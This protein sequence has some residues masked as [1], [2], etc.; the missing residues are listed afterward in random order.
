[1]LVEVEPKKKK[2]LLLVFWVVDVQKENDCNFDLD[3]VPKCRRSCLLK[4]KKLSNYKWFK[5]D[6]RHNFI[7]TKINKLWIFVP[8]MFNMTSNLTQNWPE[9]DQKGVLKLIKK[10]SKI[11]SNWPKINSNWPTL[12]QLHQKGIRNETVLV[13]FWTRNGKIETKVTW[14]GFV[15]RVT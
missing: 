9:L 1:M 3:D 11:N 12:T 5:I 4:P 6:Q 7:Q 8:K 13:H 10:R 2:Q 15:T 14:N